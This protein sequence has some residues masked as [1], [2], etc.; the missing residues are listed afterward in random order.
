MTGTR[1][2]RLRDIFLLSGGGLLFTYLIA[3]ALTVSITADEAGSWQ[4]FA[5]KGE[6]FPSTYDYYSANNH[7]LNTALMMLFEKLFGTS[8][9]VLRLPNVL[10]GGLFIFSTAMMVRRFPSP[11]IAVLAFV[12]MNTNPYMLQYF[13][14]ARGYGLAAGLM[15]FSFWQ[16]W[17][18]FDDG[19]MLKNLVAASLAA[20]LAVFANYTYLNLF[21]PLAAFTGLFI[22]FH[23][24][25]KQMNTRSRFVHTSVISVFVI[26]VLAVVIPIGNAIKAGGGFWEATYEN[27][28]TESVA[29]VINGILFNVGNNDPRLIYKCVI[30]AGEIYFVASIAILGRAFILRKEGS[31]PY[32]PLFVFTVLSLSGISVML[33]HVLLGL[34]Y[35]VQRIGLFMV[36]PLLLL[37]SLAAGTSQKNNWF[38]VAPFA[39]LTAFLAWHFAST[40][41]SWREA[42]SPASEQVNEAVA[43]LQEKTSG[44]ERV[45]IVVDPILTSN[46]FDFYI[47]TGRLHEFD[48]SVDTSFQ[49]PLNRYCFVSSAYG[50]NI[51]A[52]DWHLLRG[53]G[54]GN[55]LLERNVQKNEPVAVRQLSSVTDTVTVLSEWM[56]HYN[57]G[58]RWLDSTTDSAPMLAHVE[59]ELWKAEDAHA[60][61][62][63]YVFHDN[64]QMFAYGIDLDRYPAAEEWKR[65]EYDVVLPP[66]KYFDDVIAGTFWISGGATQIK[67]FTL[68]VKAY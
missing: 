55:M 26:A 18:Y 24:G 46:G 16:L 19:A 47:S 40:A 62:W 61:T 12:V 66:V 13:N 4:M 31:I 68:T 34:E 10:A 60:K 14:V 53:F 9:F 56:Q 58:G 23:R 54:N 49:N 51:S 8:A 48:V 67:N 44:D 50:R 42:F 65:Y 52:G 43:I 38:T 25:A 5:S 64:Q 30:F 33:Q 2:A 37:I 17:K 41:S 39:L 36:W 15:A 35:P 29:S 6:I 28:W 27:F 45:R 20:S 7:A 22:L 21:L 57:V 1:A 3:R 63:I 32:F 11:L 59:M